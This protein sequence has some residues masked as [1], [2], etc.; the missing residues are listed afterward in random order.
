MAFDVCRKL[1]RVLPCEI[2]GRFGIAALHGLDNFEVVDDGP[3]ACRNFITLD[4]KVNR[5]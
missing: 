4:G 1:E 5:A 2:F 3:G